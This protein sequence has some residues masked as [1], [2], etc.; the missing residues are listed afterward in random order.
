MKILQEEKLS[1]TCNFFRVDN[2]FFSLYNDKIQFS[3]LEQHVFLRK[4]LSYSNG[5]LPQYLVDNCDLAL[6]I[7]GNTDKAFNCVPNKLVEALSLG[8]PTLT[9]NSS[10]L[11]EF[12]NPE[13]DLWTCEPSPESIAEFIFTIATGA[14]HPVDWQFTRQKVQSTF[15]VARYQEVVNKV[16]EGV[17]HD[18]LDYRL[19]GPIM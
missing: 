11:K 10:A 16:L 6:G 15:S 18:L 14:A 13:A 17:S 19:P 5:S 3:K 9:M 8:I 7:F 12:F 4:D 2:P 1:F